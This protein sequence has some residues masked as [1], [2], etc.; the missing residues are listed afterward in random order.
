MGSSNNSHYKWIPWVGQEVLQETAIVI[1]TT[2]ELEEVRN[3]ADSTQCR[4]N[5]LEKAAWNFFM[6]KDPKAVW[7]FF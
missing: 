4:K 2:F 5:R 1:T 3:S 6:Q 7:Q